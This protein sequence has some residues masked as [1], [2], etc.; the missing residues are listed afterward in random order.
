MVELVALL[1][2][3]TFPPEEQKALK[4][5]DFNVQPLTQNYYVL[6]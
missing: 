5:E 6:F 1:Q 2:P 3:T 4:A